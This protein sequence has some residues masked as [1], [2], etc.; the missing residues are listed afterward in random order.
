MFKALLEENMEKCPYEENS[1][2]GFPKPDTKNTN[3]K[4]QFNSTPLNFKT[5][6]QH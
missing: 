3:Q 5:F 4:E 1:K 6:V 2:E